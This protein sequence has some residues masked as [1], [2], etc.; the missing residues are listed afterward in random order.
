MCNKYIQQMKVISNIVVAVNCKKR[1]RKQVIFG[2]H[3]K[4]LKMG[5]QKWHDMQSGCVKIR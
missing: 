5:D 3:V 4:S 1:A 2:S